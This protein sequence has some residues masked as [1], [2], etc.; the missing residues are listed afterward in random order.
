MIQSLK[1]DNFDTLTTLRDHLFSA[2][3]LIL[4]HIGAVELL[5]VFIP[6]LLNLKLAVFNADTNLSLDPM[7]SLL[8]LVL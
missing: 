4:R 6:S 7:S 8:L 5:L 3:I 2:L 1:L